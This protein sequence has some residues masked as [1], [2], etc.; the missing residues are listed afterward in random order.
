MRPGWRAGWGVATIELV[1]EVFGLKDPGALWPEPPALE[2]C[3]TPVR[4]SAPAHPRSDQAV[5]AMDRGD[6]AGCGGVVERAATLQFAQRSAGWEACRCA[7]D[8][9]RCAE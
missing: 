9:W 4:R 1:L 7:V 8:L 5:S 2:D 6:L 3:I